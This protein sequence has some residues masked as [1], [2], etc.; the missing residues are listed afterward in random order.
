MIY[1][2]IH[3]VNFK[4]IKI[5][6]TIGRFECFRWFFLFNQNAMTEGVSAKIISVAS[7]A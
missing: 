6:C 2:K 1:I 7:K 5:Y 4:V 3:V